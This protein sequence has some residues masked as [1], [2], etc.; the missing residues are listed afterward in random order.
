MPGTFSSADLEAELSMLKL[1]GSWASLGAQ[2][3]I[4]SMEDSSRSNP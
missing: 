2:H 1:D 4:A 3:H